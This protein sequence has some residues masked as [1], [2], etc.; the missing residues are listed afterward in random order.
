MP[1]KHLEQGQTYCGQSANTGNS[2]HEQ[3]YSYYLAFHCAQALV[4]KTPLLSV[5]NNTY[6]GNTIIFGGKL[7]FCEF[8]NGNVGP[9]KLLSIL[10]H[11]ASGFEVFR[12]L[13]TSQLRILT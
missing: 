9:V 6:R 2:Y 11:E 5:S 4:S 10:R 1:S 7:S 8:P 3:N 12:A 13:T